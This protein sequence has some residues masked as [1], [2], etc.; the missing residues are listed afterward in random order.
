MNGKLYRLQCRVTGK[1]YIGSTTGT[2][3]Y[4]L[5]KHRAASKEPH[6][7]GSPLYTHF[8]TIGWANA[9]MVL[10]TEVEVETRRALLDLEKREILLH[11]GAPLC[12][13]HNRPTITPEEKKMHDANYGKNR[14]S[15]HGDRERERVR[16][17]REEN[18]EKYEAQK[19]RSLQRQR[20]K[21]T[22]V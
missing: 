3:A 21:R 22:L 13:N 19:K 6:R 14:R 12:L 2:L 20:E 15:T 8:R 5:K 10:L 18:P 9:E 1:F 17:W 7:Q 11:I 16:K 4:R